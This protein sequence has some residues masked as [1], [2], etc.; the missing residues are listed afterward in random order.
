MVAALGVANH[1]DLVGLLALVEVGDRQPV[2]PDAPHSTT[3]DQRF[4][5][6]LTATQ[7]TAADT[8]RFEERL[9]TTGSVTAGD[10]TVD[11]GSQSQC[12]LAIASLRICWRRGT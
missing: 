1:A 8:E 7:Q 6:R 11:P 10:C 12:C 3:A 4:E 5:E 9:T 2:V